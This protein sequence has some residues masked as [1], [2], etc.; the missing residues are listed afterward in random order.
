[1]KQV[2]DILDNTDLEVWLLTRLRDCPKWR[3]KVDTEFDQKGLRVVTGGIEMFVGQNIWE[4]GKPKR[5]TVRETLYELFTLYNARWLPAT[6]AAGLVID[7]G[8]DPRS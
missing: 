1:M 4:I 5:Q 6:G 2:E 8:A 3:K 7:A